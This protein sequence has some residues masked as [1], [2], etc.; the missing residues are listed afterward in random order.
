MEW[1]EWKTRD[2]LK[3]RRRMC[4]GGGQMKALILHPKCLSPETKLFS[5]AAQQ[6]NRWR[7]G[8]FRTPSSLQGSH[9]AFPRDVRA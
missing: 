9:D 5:K 8:R 3:R 4:L 2:W 1:T 7:L 6:T